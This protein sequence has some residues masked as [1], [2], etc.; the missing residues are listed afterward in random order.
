MGKKSTKTPQPKKI[1]FADLDEKNKAE[2]MAQIAAHKQSAKRAG[3][4]V[5]R[6]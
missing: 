4:P 3:A 2:L 6:K 1:N 5:S